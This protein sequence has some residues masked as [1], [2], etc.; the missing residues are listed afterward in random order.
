MVVSLNSNLRGTLFK[1]SFLFESQMCNSFKGPNDVL[2]SSY[3]ADFMKSPNSLGP[4]SYLVLVNQHCTRE[5]MAG[6]PLDLP[7]EFVDHWASDSRYRT[8]SLHTAKVSMIKGMCQRS[9]ELLIEC[10]FLL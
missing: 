6:L 4:G 8:F 5:A 2:N 10:M 9:S 3:N 1:I 7:T